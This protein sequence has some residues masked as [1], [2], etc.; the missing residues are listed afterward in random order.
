MYN[1][2][3]MEEEPKIKK[4]LLIFV[5]SFVSLFLIAIGFFVI[6]FYNS[7][8]DDFPIRKV[9]SIEKGSSLK[10]VAREFQEQRLIRSAFAFETIGWLL[11]KESG[12]KAGEYFFE[13]Q[14][15]AISLMKEITGH[16][17]KNQLI[18]VTVIE[19]ADLNDIGTLFEK[20]GFWDSDEFFKVT[21]KPAV[22]CRSSVCIDSQTKIIKTGSLIFLKPYYASLEGYLFPDTYYVPVD[23]TPES[24]V[25]VMLENFEKKMTPELREAIN[26][27]GHSFYEILT[28]ASLIEK[29]AAKEQDRK[30][31]SGI[32]WKR[33][34]KDMLLQVDAIFPYII[35]KNSFQ[36][37][38]A[39]LKTDSPYNTYLHKGLPLGP[40]AN[41]G[42]DSIKASLFPT[43]SP[44]WYYLSDKNGNLYYSASY[45][46]HLIKKTKYLK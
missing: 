3:I 25:A 12:V 9:I 21:G 45:E 22:D 5:V 36:I 38:A 14:F 32:L 26:K 44:F 27:S 1:I 13:N 35:G 24:M 31:I 6:Y 2:I 11:K 23:I 17:Y 16:N 34:K 41:P 46:E 20:T 42:F 29:E 7:P 28:M 19:G 30:L 39:D 40:I 18:K 33:L 37:T 10:R 8:P 4:N 43:E 15:D